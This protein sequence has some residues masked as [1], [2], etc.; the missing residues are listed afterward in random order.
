MKARFQFSSILFLSLL[1]HMALCQSH[2]AK[3]SFPT[4]SQIK[5]ENSAYYDYTNY[6]GTARIQKLDSI[7]LFD[8]P[9][10]TVTYFLNGKPTTTTNYVK[11]ELSKK[12]RQV[13][14]ISIGRLDQNGK[15][16][17]TI[18]YETR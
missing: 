6:D 11:Q 7:N 18:T 1:N 9:P 3:E 4:F 17:I 10:G 5:S 2:K 12:G 16:V 14:S 8:Y 15:R 13:E